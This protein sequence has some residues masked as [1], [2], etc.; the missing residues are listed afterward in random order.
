MSDKKACRSC[1]EPISEGAKWCP[2]CHR[3]QSPLRAILHPQALAVV[4]IAL[5]GYWYLTFSAMQNT[6]SQMDQE[7]IYEGGDELEIL[8]SSFSIGPSKSGCE[9]CVYT[10]GK[11]KNNTSTAWGNIHFQASYRDAEGKV[12]DVTNDEDSDFILGPNSEGR[13]KMSGRASAD[14]ASYKTHTLKITKASPDKEWY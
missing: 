5:L 4:I 2:H 8:E 10:I 7:A 12:I 1:K 6:M 14:R 11:V 9:P 3:P 13:F